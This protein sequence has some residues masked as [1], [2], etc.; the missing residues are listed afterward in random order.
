MK[1]LKNPRRV[2]AKRRVFSVGSLPRSQVPQRFF[3]DPFPALRPP[4]PAPRSWLGPRVLEIAAPRS[5]AIFRRR[6]RQGLAN[7]S[8][9]QRCRHRHSTALLTLLLAGESLAASGVD[10]EPSSPR[11]VAPVDDRHSRHFPTELSRFA[12]G[13]AMRLAPATSSDR[14]SL[15]HAPAAPHSSP[16]LRLMAGQSFP[17]AMRLSSGQSGEPAAGSGYLELV[18]TS[19]GREHSCTHVKQMLTLCL[20]LYCTVSGSRRDI[21][22]DGVVPAAAAG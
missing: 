17:L 6:R 12:D 11:R 20:C 5:S 7:P 8:L 2:L 15:V 19:F 1:S 16:H 9:A 13:P 18:R 22:V 21:H 10:H 3:F 14:T 4:L